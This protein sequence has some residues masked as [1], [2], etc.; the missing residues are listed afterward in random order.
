MNKPYRTLFVGEL[1][2]QSALTV[3]GNRPHELADAPLARDGAGRATLRGTTLAGI[4]LATAR[5]LYGALPLVITGGIETNGGRGSAYRLFNSHPLALPQTDFFQHVGIRQAT[6]ASADDHLHSLEALPR[7]TRWPFLLEVDTH[8]AGEEAEPMAAGVLREWMR[9]RC[10]LGRGGKHGYGWMRLERLQAWRLDSSHASLWPD[11]S[12]SEHGP[13]TLAR[14]FNPHLQALDGAEL[15]RMIP[16]LPARRQW[17]SLDISGQ[18]VVGERDDSFGSGYGIDTLSIGGHARLELDAGWA[19][20]H[21]Q[22]PEG[23]NLAPEEFNPD[24]LIATAPGPDGNPQ[25]Y[26]PG[27]A[28]RGPLRHALSAWLRAGGRVVRDPCGPGKFEAHD[29]GNPVDALFG[30][31]E[32]VGALAV[33]DAY[34]DSDY[35]LIWQQHH[36]EDEFAGGVY[37]AGKFDR[38]ALIAGRFRLDLRIEGASEE[39][40]QRQAAPL[41]EILRELGSTRQLAVGGG[42][43]RGHGHLGWQLDPPRTYTYGQEE[44]T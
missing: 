14:L 7:G 3:G 11:A 20:P 43:W 39:Q 2:Q 6:G 31:S 28:L 26:I 8:N 44:P 38:L 25:P 15:A 30:S 18:L 4:L 10:Q 22:Q 24:F 16:P 34:P 1:V 37:G 5:K 40:V 41:L 23:F 17:C 35:Q 33:G 27:A 29:P 32:Q 9:G 19:Y 12:L 36:A 21:L 42:Q 13:E